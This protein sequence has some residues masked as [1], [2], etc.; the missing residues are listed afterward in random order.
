MSRY[1]LI[2]EE[3]TQ[4]ILTGLDAI[5]K[6]IGGTTTHV[7]A[8]ANLGE[9]VAPKTREHAVGVVKPIHEYAIRDNKKN[10]SKKMESHF[11]YLGEQAANKLF[12]GLQRIVRDT[13][14]LIVPDNVIESAYKNHTVLNLF[15][16]LNGTKIPLEFFRIALLRKEAHTSKHL[17]LEEVLKYSKILV[18]NGVHPS[19]IQNKMIYSTMARMKSKIK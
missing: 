14:S 3:K 6:M 11:G 5:L 12:E 7:K 18:E 4:E 9:N 17:S 16:K 8:G 2:S 13:G 1:T 19:H 10:A 15:L